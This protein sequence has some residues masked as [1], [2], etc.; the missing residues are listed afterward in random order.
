M[1]KKKVAK[2]KIVKVKVKK[3]KVI[4]TGFNSGLF[5]KLKVFRDEVALEQGI[6]GLFILND[7]VLK[8]LAYFYPTTKEL[9]LLVKGAGESKFD[10]YGEKVLSIINNEIEADGLKPE[11]DKKHEELRKSVLP[12]KP[13]IN[14]KERTEMRKAKVKE[15]I[16]L[17]TSIE[18]IA[19]DLGLTSQ[20]VVNYIGRLLV[21]DPKLDVQ[22]I[23]DSVE[24]YNDIVKSFE[25]HGT[26]KIGPVYGDFAGMVEYS[27]IMLVK[28]LLGAK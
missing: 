11:A 5:E 24:G 27:D 18:D 20:T 6:R 21:D 12:D 17:K 28:I 4:R 14:V 10:K 15:L 19:A 23:K 25:K 9:F 8:E 26:E 22:Y 13:K 7:N 3:E 16:G 1:V 2:K